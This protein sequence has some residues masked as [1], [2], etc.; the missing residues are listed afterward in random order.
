VEF[1]T[2]SPKPS[3]ESAPPNP[4]VAETDKAGDTDNPALKLS[5]HGLVVQ[6]LPDGLRAAGYRITP[7]NALQVISKLVGEPTRT[8]RLEKGDKLIYA[9][10]KHGILLYTQPSGVA[11]HLVLDFDG[12]GG[13]T[14][15]NLPFVGGIEIAHETIQART[16]AAKLQAIKDLSLTHPG[17][18]Q[19]IFGGEYHDLRLYFAYLKS[20]EQL[21]MVEMD[22]K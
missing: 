19:S 4:A 12:L 15:A 2:N 17:S 16:S 22:L 11:D 1:Q 18:D 7:Q 13:A 3:G 14:G 10:D 8:N 21:S 5:S 20:L 9:Y 6:L